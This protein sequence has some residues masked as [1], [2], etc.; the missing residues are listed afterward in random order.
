MRSR[1]SLYDA[2]A[3]RAADLVVREY[4]TSFGLA[5]RILPAQQRGRIR[6]VYAL[7][8]L[9]DE[10]VDGATEEVGGDVEDARMRLD[11]LEAET[12][13]AMRT[14]YS[15]NV[16]V[17]AFARTAREAGFGSELTAPF[18]ASMRMDLDT[19]RHDEASFARYVYGSA[20]VVG[21]MCLR[22]FLLE[23]PSS[24]RDSRYRELTSGARA[25]GAAFQKI[26]F[27]RDLADDAVRLG[28]SYFVAVD[29]HHVTEE[30]KS[31]VLADIAEDVRVAR[32]AIHRLPPSVRPA[33]AV[34]CELFAE[35]TRRLEATP[36]QDL[37]T[38]RASVPTAVK[39]RIAGRALR[40]HGQVSTTLLARAGGRPA[41]AVR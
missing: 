24:V 22:I 21:L 35:L 4:S 30:Q 17:H 29:P 38:T 27:L 13:L 16:L 37:L 6:D 11:A 32:D 19:T 9:A 31:A 40:E 33:V 2:V 39:V 15:T 25:L 8:R 12:E 14:G 34:A 10:V 1:L 26:N 41:G 20:E 36:A 5:T 3:H 18:Y 7:V 23:E 28:R